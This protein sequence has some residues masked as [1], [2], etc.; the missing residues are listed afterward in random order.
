MNIKKKHIIEAKKLLANEDYTI[1]QLIKSAK[2]LELNARYYKELNNKKQ[3][4]LKSIIHT[5]VKTQ[6]YNFSITASSFNQYNWKLLRDN[7]IDTYYFITIEPVIIPTELPELK[8]IFTVN[9][10]KKKAITE[11][12]LN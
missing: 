8:I 5:S 9:E 1:K 10:D 7:L 11:L 3:F 2:Q 6:G 12:L 4:V